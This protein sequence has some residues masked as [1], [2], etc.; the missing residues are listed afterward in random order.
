MP[1]L[2]KW[3]RRIVQLVCLFLFF[4]LLYHARWSPDG[5]TAPPIFLQFD[6]LVV[7][8]GLL[9]RGPT[10][11]LLFVPLA[12]IVIITLLLGRVFCGWLCPLG[13]IIDISDTIFWRRRSG[14]R[15]RYVRPQWKYY[16]LGAVLL[17]ALFGVQL[18]W[19]VDPIPLLTRTTATVFYPLTLGAYNL[20]VIG[21]Q[22]LL[23][24]WGLY[25]SPV[26][27]PHFSLDIVVAV[28]FVA[29]LMLSYFARRMWCRSLCPL[30][31]LLAFI[32]RFGF[33]KRYVAPECIGC[34][35]CTNACKMGAIPDDQPEKTFA[36]ECI[37]CYDCVASC[38]Q[39]DASSIGFHRYDAGGADAAT[40]ASKRAF[41]GALG[42]GL[43]YGL[44]ARFG[45]RRSEHHPQLIR[46]PGANIYELSGTRRRMTEEEFRAV[47]IR[48]GQCMRACPTG[49]L[50]PAISQAEFDGLYT[51]VLIPQV[52]FC[53][54]NC[55]AC[56]QVCPSGALQPFT[57]EEKSDIWLGRA[58]INNDICLAWQRGDD[59]RLCLICAE[60]CPYL[61]IDNPLYE[62][63]RRPFMDPAKCVGC[64]EC[65]H[66]CPTRPDRSIV[67]SRLPSG[68]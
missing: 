31:A 22:S 48:C 11:P 17:A 53:E 61:A 14:Q 47:C 18:A 45:W 30:G 7:L 25:L 21:A 39:K 6:P 12:T 55:N 19:I 51:P 63:Q 68:G 33:L 4:W 65:E 44:A 8:S 38:P 50:Q 52:G 60:H 10:G 24:G 2:G 16:I 3:L 15:A 41:I 49:G 57:I 27:V 56:G 28:M 67:V 13:T 58:E 5:S 29:I 62:G 37:L 35:R 26:T 66:F 36:A 64:G 54:Q 59:Y 46:P 40:R 9:A 34:R 23:R 32:G 42:A 20:V 1:M 43:V